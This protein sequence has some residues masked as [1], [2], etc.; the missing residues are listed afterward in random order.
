MDAELATHS[1]LGH[2]GATFHSATILPTARVLVKSKANG[3]IPVRVLLDRGSKITCIT[4]SCRKRLGIP[5]NRADTQITG[6]GGN[7]ST[8]S[9]SIVHLQLVP[10]YDSVIE[11]AAVVLGGVANPLPS[12]PIR[13]AD[14]GC[15][16]NLHWVD[17]NFATP[18]EVDMILEGDVFELIVGTK[19]KTISKELFARETVFECVLTGK[20]TTEVNSS[21]CQMIHA[22]LDNQLQNFWE[23]EEVP[24]VKQLSPE[25]AACEK[26]FVNNTENRFMVRLPFKDVVRLDDSLEQAK[27][28]FFYLE[29]RLEAKPELRFRNQKFIQELLDMQHM[30]ELPKKDLAKLPSECFYLPHHYVF[31]EDST[32]TKLRVVFDGSAKS[33]TGVSINDALMVGPVVQDDLISIII[34]FRFY[35]IA[36]SADIENM[37]RQ[38]GLKEED[39]DFHRTLW[40]DSTDLPLKHLR[41]TRVIYAV[42]C[43]A[44][45]STRTL[46][47]NCQE[48]KTSSCQKCIRIFI[49]R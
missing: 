36:L 38:V 37:Y 8:T 16:K 43:S 17:P 44:H 34:R 47:K 4:E 23:I 32:T 13:I 20:T 41:M 29:K 39:R 1:H 2:S 27:R 35:S 30:E 18:G 7:F 28:R 49:L 3:K 12:Y 46:S 11:T 40:R 26:H 6:I 33:T 14:F 10:S 45:V 22:Q 15:F 31:K 48:D 25:E 21:L 9:S 24:I 42:A 19:K 5:A